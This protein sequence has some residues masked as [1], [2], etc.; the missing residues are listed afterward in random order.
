[1]MLVRTFLIGITLA[2]V[3]ACSSN[4]KMSDVSVTAM[5]IERGMS[6]QQVLEIASDY[7]MQRTF[8]GAGTALQ[9]CEGDRVEGRGDYVVV[10]LVDD[11]VEGLTQYSR[12][13]AVLGEGCIGR[14]REIDWGQAPPDVKIKLNID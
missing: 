9:F 7:A 3:S 4:P 11:R 8:R 10:W 14:W 5:K 1:M 2:C 6:Y 12:D 13:I